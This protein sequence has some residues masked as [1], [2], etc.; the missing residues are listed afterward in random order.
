MEADSKD[1]GATQF[2]IDFARV[3]DQFP[4]INYIIDK[5]YQIISYTTKSWNSSA[6]NSGGQELMIEENLLNHSI[7]DFMD[8]ERVRNFYQKAYTLIFNKQREEI[9]IDSLDDAPDMLRDNVIYLTPI[10]DPNSDE[11]IGILHHSL[12]IKTR[13]KPSQI[14][15]L[16]SHRDP[17]QFSQVCSI[18]RFV[19]FEDESGIHKW[20]EPARY[21]QLG[22]SSAINLEHTV[23]PDCS[24]ILDDFI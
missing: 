21:F 2:L 20:I 23:C 19:N 9:K 5:K 13:E 6:K 10:M 4:G 8:G 15:D 22:G 18:C 12:I 11:V 14:S 7:F 17:S 16:P 24:N 3:I 1:T